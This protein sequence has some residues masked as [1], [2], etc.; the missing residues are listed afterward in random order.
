MAK[1]YF[2][3]PNSK[4]PNGTGKPDQRLLT[5]SER[6]KEKQGYSPASNALERTDIPT[7]NEI[8]DAAL[9]K[10]QQLS[11]VT[12]QAKP[13]T[14]IPTLTTPA[15]NSFQQSQTKSYQTKQPAPKPPAKTKPPVKNNISGNNPFIPDSVKT[16]QTQNKLTSSP[17]KKE[18]QQALSP[19]ASQKPLQYKQPASSSRRIK[20]LDDGV[21]NKLRQELEMQSEIVLQEIIDEFIPQIEAE[22]HKRMRSEINDIIDQIINP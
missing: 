19:A 17:L 9:N 2:T 13:T 12:Q 18:A 6:S 15:L 16:T 14:D 8:A 22:F 11:G 4:Q 3:K 1:L 10:D 5:E 21:R 20:S 7:L